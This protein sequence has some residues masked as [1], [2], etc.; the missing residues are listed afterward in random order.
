M[1][2][3]EFFPGI[4][5]LTIPIRLFETSSLNSIFSAI[6]NRNAV[7]HCKRRNVAKVR[8]YASGPVNISTDNL[9]IFYPIVML[10]VFVSMWQNSPSLI[11]LSTS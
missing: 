2:K 9:A 7:L 8:C 4:Y 6:N 10:S 3:N 11:T 5:I 1:I